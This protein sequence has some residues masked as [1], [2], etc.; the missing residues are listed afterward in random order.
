ML[1]MEAIVAYASIGN[2]FSVKEII[3]QLIDKP[4][5]EK[6]AERIDMDLPPFINPQ[7]ALEIP[8]LD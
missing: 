5:Y 4:T 6:I 7:G 1:A 3:F 2:K 8:Y